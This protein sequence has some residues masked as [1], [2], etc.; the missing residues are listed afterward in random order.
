MLSPE[1]FQLYLIGAVNKLERVSSK[2][3]TDGK[4]AASQI[5]HKY[6]EPFLLFAPSDSLLHF[7][8]LAEL[9]AEVTQPPLPFVPPCSFVRMTYDSLGPPYTFGLGINRACDSVFKFLTE[10]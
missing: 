7:S 4:V 10:Q 2:D 9:K 3:V 1:R 6:C 8:V 5:H